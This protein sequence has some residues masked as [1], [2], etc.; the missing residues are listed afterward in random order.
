LS[1]GRSTMAEYCERAPGSIGRAG[2]FL[3]RFMCFV[4]RQDRRG[5]AIA[6]LS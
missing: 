2:F 3:L 1:A 5:V 4:A 6:S